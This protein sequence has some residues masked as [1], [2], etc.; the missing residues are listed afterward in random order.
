MGMNPSMVRTDKNRKRKS[1]MSE[2]ERE[3]EL[4]E[5]RDIVQ[6]LKSVIEAFKA[7]FPQGQKFETIVQAKESAKMFLGQL[8]DAYDIVDCDK[9]MLLNHGFHAFLVS[10]SLLSTLCSIR[11]K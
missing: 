5:T 7:A 3:M 6:M 1:G 11:Y 8:A 2:V 9:E 4:N 10:L